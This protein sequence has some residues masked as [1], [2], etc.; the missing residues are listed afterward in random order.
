MR[1]CNLCHVTKAD[2]EFRR[3][4]AEGRRAAC[5][6][7]ESKLD[8]V[9]RA[10]QAAERAAWRARGRQ[11]IGK[12][13]NSAG[14]PELDK[15][16]LDNPPEPTPRTTV[17][18]L[19]DRRLRHDLKEAKRKLTLTL[20]ALGQTKEELA[21]VLG[22]AGARATIP[23]LEPRSR[24]SVLRQAVAVALASDWH[25]ESTVTA[26]QVNGVNAYDL[27]IAK[28]RAERF[29][30]GLRYMVQY[31]ADHFDIRELVLWLGGDLITGFLHE[32][33]VE[34]N[35][36]SPVQAIATLQVWLAD[37][38][39]SLLAGTDLERIRVPCSSGN[40]GRLTKRMRSASREAN[41]IEWLLYQTLAREFKDDPRV[42]FILPAGTH[43]YVDVLG[44]TVR[45]THGDTVNYGG[46]VG[47]I[48]I[49]I[50]KALARWQTVRHAD[51]TVMGH[52]H[53]Y[54]DLSDL[55]VNGSL[56]GYDAYAIDIG[57]RHEEPRQAFF[58]IDEK[59]GKTMPADIWVR[60]S[61][62]AA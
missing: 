14:V 43:T 23:P 15:S 3:R 27:D 61:D 45:F 50:Y 54:H 4:G 20:D 12:P 44:W 22:A 42:E 18:D 6:D 58:L 40:H 28:R 1:T 55:V 9:R 57:A 47:G 8:R 31:H 39:R 11:D 60:D 56:I 17:D 49:P 16:C 5:R 38:I 36:L 46:G 7:C 2:T 21:T 25:I 29:F 35:S 34:T 59:R 41:S 62:E 52:F 13:D 53:Q 51:L 48:T 10:T 19:R 24:S 33:N 32:D 26:E 37:G 30:G